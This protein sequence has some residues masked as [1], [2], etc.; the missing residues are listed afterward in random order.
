MK[1]I[2]DIAVK[3][4]NE[5]KSRAHNH[6]LFKLLCQEI[7]SEYELLLFHTEFR[8][9]LQGKFLKRLVILKQEVSAFLGDRNSILSAKFDDKI[10]MDS[11]IYQI[12]FTILLI[13]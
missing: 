1:D 9:V 11:H 5:I 10:F 13:M 6:R 4:V 8:W 3:A 2:L 7:G 12:F